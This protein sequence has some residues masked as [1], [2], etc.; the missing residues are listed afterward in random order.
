MKLLLFQAKKK[1]KKIQ[2]NQ[3]FREKKARKNNESEK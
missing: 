3:A 1:K 2:K